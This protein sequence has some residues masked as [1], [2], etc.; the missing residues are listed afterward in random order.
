MSVPEHSEILS[1]PPVRTQKSS[2]KM[3]KSVSPLIRNNKP[4]QQKVAVGH[5]LCLSEQFPSKYDLSSCGHYSTT[6]ICWT[7]GNKIF[8]FQFFFN[9]QMSVVPSLALKLHPKMRSSRK[10]SAQTIQSFTRREKFVSASD[11]K[12]PAQ[13]QW[14]WVTLLHNLKS[15][16]MYVIARQK[17]TCEGRV[18]FVALFCFARLVYVHVLTPAP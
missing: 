6:C 15:P 8:L 4:N 16:P 7:A 3:C 9:N 17:D 11:V 18:R 12:Q 13:F 2:G 14:F 5:L 1:W 10:V